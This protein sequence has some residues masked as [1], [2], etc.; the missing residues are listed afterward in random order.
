MEGNHTEFSE[1]ET[2]LHEQDS[3]LIQIENDTNPFVVAI[4]PYLAIRIVGM[5]DFCQGWRTQGNQVLGR[6][7]V[8]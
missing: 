1:V 5:N 7:V 8:S 4:E 2:F 3:R 6:D